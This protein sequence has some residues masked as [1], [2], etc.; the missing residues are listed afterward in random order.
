MFYQ[1]KGLPEDSE[2]VMCTVTNIQYSSV[3]VTID[4]YKVS[5][6]IHISEIAAGR[7]RN[8]RDYVK[9]GKKVVCKVLRVYHDKGH[10]DLSLRRVNERERKIKVN[11]AKF[12]Q[13]AESIIHHVAKENKLEPRKLYD[14]V[15][16][17]LFK[18]YAYLH[19]AFEDIVAENLSL[20]SI[21][22][23]KKIAAQIEELA[24]QRFKPQSVEISG[25][26]SLTSYESNGLD[27]VKDALI[28]A[29]K[30][31]GVEINYL[32]GGKYNIVATAPNYKEAEPKLKLAVETAVQ[33]MEKTKGYSDFKRK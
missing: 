6:M 30:A 13:K 15:T 21:G 33:K 25:V 10:V 29:K 9:E 18:S 4:D 3:F 12:E 5:G 17:E 8:I 26:L 14:D 11:E 27:I 31:G 20:S 7:I 28:E 24:N 32:G 2:I 22:I 19:H 23:D 16:K 1:K